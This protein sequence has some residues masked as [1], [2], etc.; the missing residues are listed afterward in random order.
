MEKLGS[1]ETALKILTALLTA[2]AGVYAYVRFLLFGSAKAADTYLELKVDPYQPVVKLYGRLI[3][4]IGQPVAI[5]IDDLDRCGSDYVAELIEG[6]Q[7]LLRAESV[8]YVVAA[9]RKWICAAF[10]KKYAD[11]TS[12]IG[13]PT[14]PLGYLFLDKLFQI[15]APLPSLSPGSRDSF[16]SELLNGDLPPET[17]DAVKTAAVKIEGKDSVEA[18]RDAIAKAPEQ[19]KAAFRAAAALKITSAQSTKA[20]EHSLQSIRGLIEPNPRAMK[21]LV[22][23]V[24]MAQARIFLEARDVPLDIVA[25]WTLIEL[26]W[27]LLADHLRE[28]PSTIDRVGEKRDALA[29]AELPPPIASMMNARALKEIVRPKGM[30]RLD[31]KALEQLLS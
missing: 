19:E 12:T 31:S 24:G 8:T 7:T 5:F 18:L 17:A 21:R 16:W 4:A 14:R 26:R 29:T 6:V 11:F 1:G 20:I 23:A 2:A 15:S 30:A 10:E 9:D 13:E 27:P 25:R 3:R 22:N 28:E